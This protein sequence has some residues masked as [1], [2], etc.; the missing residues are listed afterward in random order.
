MGDQQSV[1][2]LPRVIAGP[3][4][5]P[6]VTVQTLGRPYLVIAGPFLGT[7][8]RTSPAIHRAACPIGGDDLAARAADGWM[9]GTGPGMTGGGDGI[10][11]AA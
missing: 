6:S 2:S 11:L 8:P 3:F 7:S 1:A 4:L 9:P 5:A 10:A